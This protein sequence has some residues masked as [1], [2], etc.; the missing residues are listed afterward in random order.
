MAKRHRGARGASHHIAPQRQKEPHLTDILNKTIREERSFKAKLP[1]ESHSLLSIL[2][3]AQSFTLS[4]IVN[5]WIALED[6][7]SQKQK[8]ILALTV[9]VFD[10]SR[11]A[12]ILICSG[13][14][15]QAVMLVR[16][17][18]ERVMTALYFR[19][20]P[21]GA[22]AWLEDDKLPEHYATTAKTAVAPLV[23]D[24][25]QWAYAQSLANVDLSVVNELGRL[26]GI[27][28]SFTHPHQDATPWQ[29]AI[30]QETQQTWSA[31]GPN[32]RAVVFGPVILAFLWFL[33][34]VLFMI[35]ALE[36]GDAAGV[37]PW[38]DMTAMWESSLSSSGA[39]AKAMEMIK[40]DNMDD[41]WNYPESRKQR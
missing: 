20:D 7:M 26:Y 19:S 13:Y 24:Y 36:F 23:E 2:R 34:I 16:G 25:T 30:D 11:A 5:R 9:A 29:F 17:V 35:L 21:S 18:Y 4:A 33:H 38:K 31:Y 15:I 27:L 28:C 8:A 41:W 32:E 14:P 12:E 39:V 6:A 22:S 10:L 37:L 1:P 3:D 40:A